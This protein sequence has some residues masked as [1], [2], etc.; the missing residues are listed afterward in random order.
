MR[1]KILLNRLKGPFNVQRLAA[2]VALAIVASSA[3]VACGPKLST[4]DGSVTIYGPYFGA[5]A[6]AFQAE[7]D[8]FS[9]S[10]G[11]QAIYK[12]IP[13]MDAQ[14]QTDTS[15]STLPDIAIWDNPRPLLAHTGQMVSLDQLVDIEAIRKTLVPGWNEVAKSEGK[16]FGLPT[17]SNIKTGVKSLV[18]YNPQAFERLGY[19]VPSTDKELVALIQQIQKDKSGYP[20]CAGIESGGATGWVATDWIEHYVLSNEGVDGYNKW[21]SGALKFDSAEISKAANKVSDLL[22]S[23]GHASGGGAG[24][25]RENFGKTDAL[26]ASGGK[27]SGQCFM[28]RHGL[29]ITDFFPDAIKAEISQDDYA[30]ANAFAL[31]ASEGGKRAVLGD[32]YL[33]SAFSRDNDVA[34]VLNFILSDRF[35]KIMVKTTNFLSPHKTFPVGQYRDGLSR[36]AAVTFTKAEVFGFDASTAMPD[37]VS[38]QF[39]IS[40]TKWINESL[41]W[42]AVASE[43]DAAF[44]R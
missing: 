32:G 6:D 36:V 21:I 26:F 31:P 24:M 37:G 27:P 19:K 4:G 11:I 39:W 12:P 18:F 2:S 35:G 34:E 42:T 5:E 33:A 10:S 23:P 15:N 9:V 44:G 38:K 20:W 43:I 41:E 8:N 40:S 13:D 28:M 7:L 17:S 3:L 30:H 1:S 29:Y 22:L 16:T 14:I 25:A